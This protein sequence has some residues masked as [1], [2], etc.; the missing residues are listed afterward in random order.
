MHIPPHFIHPLLPPGWVTA[1]DPI[2]GHPYYANP[3]TGETS[4]Q[5]PAVSI[6][7]PPP[8]PPLSSRASITLSQYVIPKSSSSFRTTGLLIPAA[9]H[10]INTNLDA[11]ENQHSSMEEEKSNAMPI[12]LKMK[13]GM[14]VDL[15]NVQSK[16]RNE[17][18]EVDVNTSYESLNPFELPLWTCMD[19][20]SEGTS[21]LDVR[22]VSL[23]ENL[24][25]IQSTKR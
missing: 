10:I 18:T 15:T 17:Q 8:P 13:A 3:N 24:A 21:R 19:Q 11:V 14:I 12:E 20:N 7:P 22:L 5:P 2:S 23:M 9:R 4:W 1:N 25:N 16:Y 6:P